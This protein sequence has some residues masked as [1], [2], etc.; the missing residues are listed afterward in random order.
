MSAGDPDAL[1]QWLAISPSH[2]PGARLGVS[3]LDLH[4]YGFTSSTDYQA[5]VS[6][7]PLAA[8][9]TLSSWLGSQRRSKVCILR[10]LDGLICSGELLLVLGRPGSGCSTFL[11]TLTGHTH[12]IYLGAESQ[13]NYQGMLRYFS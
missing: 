6:S 5:T 7:Y 2:G 12:G 3:F 11:K 8:L 1:G 9:S 4:V 13:I 10:G